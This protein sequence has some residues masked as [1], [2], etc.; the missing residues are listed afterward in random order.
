MK[1]VNNKKHHM[2]CVISTIVAA[3]HN[4]MA[5]KLTNTLISHATGASSLTLDHQRCGRY[6]RGGAL[7]LPVDSIWG[8]LESNTACDDMEFFMF[9][10]LS[11]ES[12]SLLVSICEGTINSTPLNRDCGAPDENARKKRLFGPRGVMAMT[13]KFLTSVAEP[14]DLYPQFGATSNVFRQGV[15]LGMLSIIANINHPKIRVYWDRSAEALR[16]QAERTSMFLD[17]KGVVGM[18]DGRKMVSLQPTE[19]LAQNRD[20]NGWT[21]EVNRNVVL[22]W[23]T[24]GLIV[25]AAVNT[26]GNFHDSKSSL[27]AR[28]YDHIADLPDGFVVVCDSAFHCS[29]PMAGKL[30]KLKEDKGGFAFS[31]YDQSLTHLRQ[32]SE[33]GNGVLCN[34]FRRLRAPLPTDNVRRAHILWS[35]ILMH[36]FRTNTCDRNQIRTYFDNLNL[37]KDN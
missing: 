30:V 33:W 1:E 9:I 15:E 28:I 17:I 27:W 20:Y 5:N 4:E 31:G 11:H 2:A 8:R 36:N 6:T 7:P 10:G 29:G 21:K 18:I 24:D 16:K 25:D 34:A 23:D 26:P 14:K 32:S 3:M 22:L 13:I 19:W 37:T 12:F 35:C